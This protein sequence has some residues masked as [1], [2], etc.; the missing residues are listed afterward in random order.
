[1]AARGLHDEHPPGQADQCANDVE[2]VWAAAVSGHASCNRPGDED[3]AEREDPAEVVVGL[4]GGPPGY[5]PS[6]M[7]PAD[8]EPALVLADALPDQPGASDLE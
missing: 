1:M 2:A 6:P 7:T 4:E 3:P 5:T 8:P